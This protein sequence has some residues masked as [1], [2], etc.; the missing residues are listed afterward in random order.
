M[1]LLRLLLASVIVMLFFST[2][3]GVMAQTTYLTNY[4]TDGGNPGGLYTGGDANT[5]GTTVI[6]A[7]VTGN[8]WSAATTIGFPFNFYGTPV[9]DFIVSGNGVVSFT[10]TATAVP[11]SANA[12]LP[13]T[14]ENIPDL[15]ILGFWDAFTGDGTT[16]SN[17]AI[18]VT[19]EGTAPNRQLWINYHSYEY[20]DNGSGGNVSSY[21][22]WSIVLEETT[23]KIY[24]VDKNYHSGGASLTATVG[25][26][27]NA[28][29]A[30][31]HGTNMTSMSS[32]GTTAADND[33]YEFTPILLVNDN[34]GVESIDA[35]VSP[36]STGS[37]NVDVTI[38][39]H[40]LNALTSATVN[41]SINGTLQTPY[42]YTGNLGQ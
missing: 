37:Q 8:G 42:S 5:A 17:D 24:I 28:T 32:G 21:T 29:S 2:N 26:Q 13:A 30:V 15:S 20:G 38:K 22:Y 9:T 16:G 36:L 33:Y 40:G 39:N 7:S 6:P 10:T 27:E 1:R 25:V 11:S 19:T 12:N 31:Q 34:A 14:A 4:V 18:Y 23:N 35:P 41:W 3:N